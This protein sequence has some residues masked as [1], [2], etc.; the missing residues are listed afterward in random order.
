M[1]ANLND[2]RY[3]LYF[4]YEQSL[5]FF[6]GNQYMQL[7]DVLHC[8]ST[9]L[10]EKNLL[11]LVGLSCYLLW[12]RVNS[13]AVLIH[14]FTTLDLRVMTFFS[15]HVMDLVKFCLLQYAHCWSLGYAQSDTLHRTRSVYN[16]NCYDLEQR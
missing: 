16:K 13:C 2:Y 10:I 8:H 11:V 1:V 3:Y 6:L 15:C 12:H 4:S 5:V 14:I 7:M 9:S